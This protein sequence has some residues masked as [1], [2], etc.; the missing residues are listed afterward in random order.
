MASDCKVNFTQDEM[1]EFWNHHFNCSQLM[2][3]VSNSN[4][5][6]GG[7]PLDTAF[8]SKSPYR[9]GSLPEE[10]IAVTGLLSGACNI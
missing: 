9:G 8:S 10:E 1:K 6:K 5:L 2:I 3:L 4:S 7:S